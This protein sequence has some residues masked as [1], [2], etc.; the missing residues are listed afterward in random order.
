MKVKL[1]I[2]FMRLIIS[3]K[4]AVDQT[5]KV[6]NLIYTVIRASE[7]DPVPGLDDIDLDPWGEI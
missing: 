6:L 4:S 2:E 7:Y 5:D 3:Y 1:L